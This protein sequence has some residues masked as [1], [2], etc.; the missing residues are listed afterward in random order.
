VLVFDLDKALA[1]VEGD[2]QLLSELLDM[3]SKQKQVLM[4]DIDNAISQKKADQ[5]R[6]SAH[7]LKGALSNLGGN[8]AAQ[9]AMELERLGEEADFETS[10]KK[11]DQLVDEIENFNQAT[12]NLRTVRSS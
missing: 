6:F 8:R 5:L 9:V 11:Y 3:F 4:G 10:R 7:S 12:A 2:R 1:A